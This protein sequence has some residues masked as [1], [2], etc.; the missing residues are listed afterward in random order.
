[1]IFKQFP[2]IILHMEK[3]DLIKGKFVSLIAES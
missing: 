2:I 1:M 3:N